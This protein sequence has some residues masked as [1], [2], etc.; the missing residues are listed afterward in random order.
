MCFLSRRFFLIVIVLVW[1]VPAAS[2]PPDSDKLTI[3]LSNDDGYNAPG[4]QAL[5]EALE[6]VSDLYVAAP[7]GNQSGKGHRLKVH[8]SSR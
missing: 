6:P 8:S 4:L 3:L 1:A 5:I 7:A 2:R